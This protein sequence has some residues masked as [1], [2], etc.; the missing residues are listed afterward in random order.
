MCPPAAAVNVWG[1]EDHTN[2]WLGIFAEHSRL[3]GHVSLSYLAKC[4]NNVITLSELASLSR[5][6]NKTAVEIVISVISLSRKRAVRHL[7]RTRVGEFGDRPD[8]NRRECEN[9]FVLHT[10]K[11]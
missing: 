1:V 9:S 8:A 4:Q 11:N 6:F 10:G 2:G 3:D 7:E 5:F